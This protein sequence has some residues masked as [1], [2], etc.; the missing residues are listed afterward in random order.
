MSLP[1]QSQKIQGFLPFSERLVIG[2]TVPERPQQSLS[3]SSHVHTSMHPACLLWAPRGGGDRLAEGLPSGQLPSTE[4]NT[5][6]VEGSPNYPDTSAVGFGSG[7]SGLV[8]AE[9]LACSIPVWG[10]R[11]AAQLRGLPGPYLQ[12]PV[13]GT[14]P[15]RCSK[16]IPLTPS[17]REMEIFL[18]GIV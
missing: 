16:P 6:S 14:D 2:P 5:F 8:L 3:S 13:N 4:S 10:G 17:L 18:H 9:G 12:A 15:L 7:S 1:D 11:T